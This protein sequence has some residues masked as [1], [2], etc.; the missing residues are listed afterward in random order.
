MCKAMPLGAAHKPQACAVLLLVA[1][2][3]QEAAAD[4]VGTKPAHLKHKA[5]ILMPLVWAAWQKDTA[6]LPWVLKIRLQDILAR[7]WDEKQKQA[8]TLARQWDM[9]QQQADG[10]ARQ[11]DAEQEQAER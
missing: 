9:K 2:Y 7:Q 6:L 1:G 11:W 5:I 4:K 3:R 10:T 8:D